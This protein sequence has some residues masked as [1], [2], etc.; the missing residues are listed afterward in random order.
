MPYSYDKGVLLSEERGDFEGGDTITVAE[1]CKQRAGTF[2]YVAASEIRVD[3][4]N[5]IVLPHSAT[6][7]RMSPANPYSKVEW[8]GTE[9]YGTL[10]GLSSDGLRSPQRIVGEKSAN[11]V[12]DVGDGYYTVWGRDLEADLQR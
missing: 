3:N 7:H 1:L 9:L 6:V 10:Q 4:A 8:G 2:G 11:L 5:V 12:I